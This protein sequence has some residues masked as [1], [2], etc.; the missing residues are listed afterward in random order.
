V[1]GKGIIP[2]RPLDRLGV[3]YYYIDV[4]SVTVQG[5]FRER[6]FLRDEQG[7][8]VFYNIAVTP[9]MQVTPDLQVVKGAQK[10]QISGGVNDVHTATV[11]GLRLNL[12]F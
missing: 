1:G 8:E 10:Q 5:P 6:K 2:G 11:L 4:Q 9:W 12:V 7:V 3:G